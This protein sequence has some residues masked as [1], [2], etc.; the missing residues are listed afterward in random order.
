M[1]TA[2]GSIGVVLTLA[3]LLPTQPLSAQDDL[4]ETVSAI[5]QSLWQGWKDHN[6]APFREHIVEN[7]VQIGG[8]GLTA[9]TEA[10]L[11]AMGEENTC[12]VESFALS[13]WQVHR[14]AEDALILTYNATQDA[15]CDGQQNDP[16]VVSSAVY[17]RV[18][19][20]W[21]AASYQESPRDE[22]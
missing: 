17:V 1:R 22:M 19:G 5:E 10:V 12:D 21:M 3:F 7:H 9:G 20:R 15:V 18:D 13:N 11:S 14:I 16:E 2:L 8:D 4:L 6:A